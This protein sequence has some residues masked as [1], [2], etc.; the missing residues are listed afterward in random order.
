MFPFKRLL[1]YFMCWVLSIP[2]HAQE[3]SNSSD[4]F[5]QKLEQRRI[6]DY[7]DKSRPFF[8]RGVNLTVELD[9]SARDQ[10]YAGASID[11]RNNSGSVTV[12][13]TVADFL[14]LS[15]ATGLGAQ[16]TYLDQSDGSKPSELGAQHSSFSSLSGAVPLLR[17][18]AEYPQVSLSGQI[19]HLRQAGYDFNTFGLGLRFTRDLESSALY[20]GLAMSRTLNGPVSSPNSMTADIGVALVVN[21]RFSLSGGVAVTQ[22]PGLLSAVSGAFGMI[23][24][25]Y[26]TVIVNSG[27][28]VPLTGSSN[29]VGLSVAL[30][31]TF[32]DTA[33]VQ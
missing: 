27:V 8:D 10:P 25:I 4:T 32:G 1:F 29:G 31:S 17:E 13:G 3:Q 30:T 33:G 7:A 11:Q 21:H 19:G 12:S 26:P 9:H 15:L 28:S 23:Y 24:A 22:S 14:S 16:K 6:S 2:V 5:G 18:T 20:G